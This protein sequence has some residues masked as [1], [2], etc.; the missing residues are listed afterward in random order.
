M[1]GVNTLTRKDPLKAQVLVVA[2]APRHSLGLQAHPATPFPAR[3]RRFDAMRAFWAADLLNHP[4]PGPVLV[5][6]GAESDTFRPERTFQPSNQGVGRSEVEMSRG[7]LFALPLVLLVLAACDTGGPTAQSSPSA[8]PSAK[9]WPT[10]GTLA[11][12]DGQSADGG[13]HSI[14]VVGVANATARVLTKVMVASRSHGAQK[15]IG[16]PGPADPLHVSTSRTHVYVLD[17]DVNVDMLAPD[18]SL[19]KVTSVVGTETVHSIFAVSPDDSELAVGQIDSVSGKFSLYLENLH[20]G[21]HVDVFAGA[22]PTYWPVGWHAGKVVLATASIGTLLNPYGSSG[23]ALIDPIA[24]AQPTALGN[25]DCVPSGTLTAAGTACIV[26][27]GTPCLEGLVANAVSPYYY[28][29]CLRRIAWNGVETTFLLPNN[30]YTSTFTVRYA[31]LSPGGD[32]ITTDQLG[33]VEAPVSD[34]HGGNE[35]LGPGAATLRPP[36]R[37]CMGWIDGTTFSFSYV[38][39]DGSTN[40]QLMGARFEGSTEI[41]P[42]VLS[43]PVDGELVGTVPDE[44]G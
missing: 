37:P 23:Y 27:P 16:C 33:K 28:N 5:R 2:R 13:S 39:P 14:W 26:R 10:T 9:G 19:T 44:L 41:A 25:G 4:L 32:Q 20:G 18:G 40:V 38:N 43:S 30:A 34:T 17:G 6:A 7:T 12:Y 42:G 22:A 31:A 15:C 11:V 35:F 1:F 3:P 8:A 36:A 21:G 24:G 29:S